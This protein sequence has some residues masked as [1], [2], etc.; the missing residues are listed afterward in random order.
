[1][2]YISSDE[3][4]RNTSEVF[5]SSVNNE[6][7]SHPNASTSIFKQNIEKVILFFKLVY[8]IQLQFTL[9]FSFL[10]LFPSHMSGISYSY[11]F[12][13]PLLIPNHIFLS[14]ISFDIFILYEYM[15]NFFNKPHPL[16]P[17]PS[18]I[19]FYSYF[20]YLLD[21]LIKC[22]LFITIYFSIN[23]LLEQFN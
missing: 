1:M 13:L 19:S 10:S 21:N 6:K 8:N 11:S 2:E 4:N 12:S 3:E 15:N 16:W 23:F 14:F 20:N 22:L 9:I 18:L 17:N 7:N 5:A